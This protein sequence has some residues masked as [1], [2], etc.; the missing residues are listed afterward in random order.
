M[1][2][3]EPQN[4]ISLPHGRTFGNSLLD[5]AVADPLVASAGGYRGNHDITEH[6]PPT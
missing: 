2:R 5:W 4:T 1:L 3:S 6:S